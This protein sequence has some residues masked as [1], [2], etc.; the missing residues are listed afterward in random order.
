MNSNRSSRASWRVSN[1]I[2]RRIQVV[3]R[4][5]LDRS[6]SRRCQPVALRSDRGD[7]VVLGPPVRVAHG[8]VSARPGRSDGSARPGHRCSSVDGHL[9]GGRS[10][11]PSG[12][13]SSVLAGGRASFWATAARDQRRSDILSAARAQPLQRT[14]ASSKTAATSL[15]S[16]PAPI[17]LSGIGQVAR[18]SRPSVDPSSVARRGCRWR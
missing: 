6:P 18:R 2:D 9:G 1:Q 12:N 16:A 13:R 14:A 10:L 11:G 3:S 15:I 5:V 7:D 17:P 8:Q 4:S